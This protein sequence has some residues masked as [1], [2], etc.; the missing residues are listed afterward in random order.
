VPDGDSRFTFHFWGALH[1][2]L[3]T[4]LRFSIASHPQTEGQTEWTINTLEDMLRDYVLDFCG[5]WDDHLP[6]VEF[7]YNNSFHSSIG[8]LP[9]EAL[10][11]RLCRSPIC[12]E[13]VGYKV[14]LGPEVIEQTFE[15]I[16]L[17]RARMRATAQDC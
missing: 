14:L 6:L 15:K 12:W 10:Y 8:M 1:E 16:R 11:G 13:E 4:Q 2:V 7:T 3:G 17:I 5:S 9:Y